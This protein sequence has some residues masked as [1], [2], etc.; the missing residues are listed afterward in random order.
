MSQIRME[1]NKSCLDTDSR[2][3]EDLTLLSEDEM[4][5]SN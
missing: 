2:S 5:E 3:H 4:F 1:T